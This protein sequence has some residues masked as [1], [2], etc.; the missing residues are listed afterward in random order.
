MKRSL[1]ASSIVTAAAVAAGIYLSGTTTRTQAPPANAP[2]LTAAEYDAMFKTNNNWGRWGKDDKLGAINL[3]T[4]AKRKQA[5]ALVKS[6]TSVSIAHDL[7][8]AEAPDNPNPLKMTMGA[9]FR[10]DTLEFNYHGTFVT[11]IDS[12]CHYPYN[13]KLYND[14]PVTA[15]NAKGCAIGI[16]N[17]KDGIVT[18]GVLIDIP[19]LKG[20]PYLEPATPVSPEEVDAWLKKA[21]VKVTA[22]DAVFLRTGRWARRAKVGPWKAL[23]NAAGLT[24]HIIPWLKSHDVALL[25]GDTTADVQ[26]EPRLIDGEAGR[27]PLHTS[28]A[29][30]GLNLIDDIDPEALADTAAKL[31][32][33]EFMVVVAP[34]RVPGGTGGPV[35]PIA[36]F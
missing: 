14:I 28:I 8:T 3:I 17:L 11:H 31:N 20:V 27:M 35:N 22:G 24:A 13:G 7:S 29:W 10:T 26:S 9:N 1:V 18:R 23:G 21:G 32:R 25:G 6:G 34:L 19:R 4:D 33:W 5:A 15:S 16:D 30:L 36:I 2:R 12:L